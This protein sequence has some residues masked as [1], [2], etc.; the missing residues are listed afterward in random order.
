MN[1]ENFV[2]LI[3]KLIKIMENEF[4]SNFLKLVQAY[5]VTPDG[6][7]KISIIL[8]LFFSFNFY[9]YVYIKAGLLELESDRLHVEKLDAKWRDLFEY[10]HT[11]I[12]QSYIHP[13]APYYVDFN[14]TFDYKLRDKQNYWNANATAV[15]NFSVGLDGDS[16]RLIRGCTSSGASVLEAICILKSELATPLFEVLSRK[17]N[18]SFSANVLYL[19]WLPFSIDEKNRLLLYKQKELGEIVLETFRAKA[20][21]STIEHFQKLSLPL[22]VATN[23]QVRRFA[24]RNMQILIRNAS[25]Y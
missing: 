1:Y 5:F 4:P 20:V 3:N 8:A 10:S 6:L 15:T 19:L 23:P 14:E 9:S 16:M 22:F 2:I 24:I 18:T 17:P 11:P 13:S 12:G 7:A 21:H 25:E